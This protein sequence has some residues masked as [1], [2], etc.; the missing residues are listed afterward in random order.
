MGYEKIFPSLSRPYPD[1]LLNCHQRNASNV[2]GNTHGYF[3]E[4]GFKNAHDTTKSA[5]KSAAPPHF[6]GWTDDDVGYINMNTLYQNTDLYLWTCIKKP[7]TDSANILT[8]TIT[9]LKP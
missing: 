4:R 2:E 6:G 9:N 3:Y 8:D 7:C 5:T 1:G